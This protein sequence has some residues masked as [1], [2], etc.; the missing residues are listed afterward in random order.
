MLPKG[1]SR[2]NPNSFFTILSYSNNYS[3]MSSEEF[4]LDFVACRDLLRKRLTEA[5]ARIQ[6]V[7]GPRQ[8]GKSTMLLE[9]QRE[10]DDCAIYA[11]A[12]GPEAALPG[13]WQRLW[14]RA[15]EH[16]QVH[17]SAVLFIDEIQ[18]IADWAARLKAE[19]DRVWRQRRRVH[20]VAT[21]S[22]S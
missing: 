10:L 16:A 19:W 21:G 4:R 13:F 7:T 22:S 2:K 8:V 3:S 18:H 6:L 9:L 12:D 1:Y 17:G 5:P 14:Q 11:A 15:E 20:V